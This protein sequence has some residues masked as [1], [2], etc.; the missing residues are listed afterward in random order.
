MTATQEH[1]PRDPRTYA[2]D[3][4]RA[5]LPGH[6]DWGRTEVVVWR[7]TPQ[8]KADFEAKAEAEG[9]AKWKRNEWG[10]NLL[11]KELYGSTQP[12]ASPQGATVARSVPAA[13]TTGS[14]P[15][16]WKPILPALEERVSGQNFQ[17]W[18]SGVRFDS[19][20]SD[21]IVLQVP[22]AFFQDYL[23]E[24]Y[25]EVIQEQLLAHYGRSFEV[26]LV[27]S[28]EPEAPIAAPTTTLLGAPPIELPPEPQ[29]EEGL[30]ALEL[31]EALAIQAQR[32]AE[33]AEV[34]RLQSI[35]A[36]KDAFKL[37][38]AR[39]ALDDKTRLVA[40]ARRR[41]QLTARA[42]PALLR[43]PGNP[44][45]HRLYH[46]REWR[47]AA[48]DAA[49][50]SAPLLGKAS[51]STFETEG[52]ATRGDVRDAEKALKKPDSS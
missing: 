37:L 44:R 8:M 52:P 15:D 32:E 18:L 17:I 46:D 38:E 23:G 24:H 41:A 21:R 51:Q 7:V 33:S 11:A 50:R 2:I 1:H 31:S 20:T 35:V 3:P 9:Y 19:A 10:C 45:D 16:L 27:V 25:V 30:A 26:D 47:E 4:S 6:P 22:N 42:L 14:S 34:R 13:L 5:G 36:Q 43:Q 12:L 28:Q 29:T 49:K 48:G 39:R 40:N